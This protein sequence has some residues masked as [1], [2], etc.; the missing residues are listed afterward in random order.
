MSIL[1]VGGDS[2]LSNEFVLLA[3][4]EEVIS[5]TR[6]LGNSK[7]IYL[8]LSEVGDFKIPNNVDSAII[9]AGVTSY[10]E[11]INNYDYAYN[12]NC[13]SVPA[14]ISELLNRDIFTC[15]ISSNTVFKSSNKIPDELDLPNPGFKYANMKYETERAITNISI[16]LQKQHLLS[17]LRMTKNVSCYTRPFD[18]WIIN[19]KNKQ[20]FMAFEDLYFSPIRFYDSANVVKKIIETKSPGVFHISGE[21]D[22]SYSD[23]ALNLLDYLG[24]KNNIVKSVESSDIGVNLVYNHNVTALNMRHTKKKLDIEEVPL[25]AIYAY[26]EK[27][28]QSI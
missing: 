20:E 10:D 17:V 28:L 26:F 16:H 8:N 7:S 6:R 3:E 21:K 12:I 2:R 22:I 5:T 24:V 23:F 14:L 19:I 25:P 1:I 27:C 15:F 13:V 11:C 9:M 4:G 18:Q